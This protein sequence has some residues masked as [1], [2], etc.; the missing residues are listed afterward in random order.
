M[1]VPCETSSGIFNRLAGERKHEIA[2]EISKT[3]EVVTARKRGFRHSP[4]ASALF[5][6]LLLRHDTILVKTS[7]VS[8]THRGSCIPTSDQIILLS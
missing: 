8:R 1:C 7:G 5:S 4:S 2:G 6:I 3:P